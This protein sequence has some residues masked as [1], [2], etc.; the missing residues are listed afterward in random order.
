MRSRWLWL[1]LG[2]APATLP[3]HALPAL[4]VSAR[5]SHPRT[6][7][8]DAIFTHVGSAGPDAD[9]VGHQQLVT[10]VLRD[11]GGRQVGRSRRTARLHRPNT[12]ERQHAH[13]R[14]NARNRSLPRRARAR[15][16]TGT[17]ETPRR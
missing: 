14:R 11:A 17:S 15:S 9:H 2:F 5:A 6:L 4:G 3:G 12:G 13:V 16:S 7:F 8:F 10:G 1:M